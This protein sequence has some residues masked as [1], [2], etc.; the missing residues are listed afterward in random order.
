MISLFY[1]T[2]KKKKCEHGVFVSVKRKSSQNSLDIKGCHWTLNITASILVE[3]IGSEWIGSEWIGCLSHVS[4]YKLQVEA[5]K[6]LNVLVLWSLRI[7]V[8]IWLLAVKC[9]PFLPSR[10]VHPSLYLSLSQLSHSLGP[11]YLQV[12]HVRIQKFWTGNPWI[13]RGRLD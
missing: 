2:S 12:P 9:R 4:D 13:Q 11:L 6:W 10:H 7:R 3:W 5:S 8:S 1:I